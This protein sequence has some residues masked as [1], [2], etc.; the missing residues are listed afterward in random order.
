[1][2]ADSQR[3]LA[4]KNAYEGADGLAARVPGGNVRMVEFWLAGK[5][6][7]TPSRAE[8]VNELARA[9]GLREPFAIAASPPKPSPGD[10]EHRA[11]TFSNRDLGT[12]VRAYGDVFLFAEAAATSVQSVYRWAS[13]EVEPKPKLAARVN[14]LA[15]AK[16]LREPFVPTQPAILRELA[17]AHGGMRALARRVGAHFN[18][19]RR[20]TR[21]AQPLA[22]AAMRLNALARA[23]KLPEVFVERIKVQLS[24]RLRA[25]GVAC[26]ADV[27]AT[28]ARASLHAVQTWDRGTARPTLRMAVRVNELARA[29]ALP[30]PF[31]PK[32]YPSGPF[33][34]LVLVYGSV[35]AFAAEIPAS[36]ESIYRWSRDELPRTRVILRINAMARESGVPEPFSEPSTRRSAGS[37]HDGPPK[38]C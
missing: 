23:Q 28:A 22:D 21:G 7:P 36:R 25:L 11:R 6:C 33:A 29:H 26:G 30:D 17:R 2:F 35:A 34:D 5:K 12:V 14:A 13:R 27:I 9:K 16:G 37:K 18:S 38:R 20:W 8:C 32:N 31:P 19:V 3:L 15:R 4:V 10:R 1:V 24:G